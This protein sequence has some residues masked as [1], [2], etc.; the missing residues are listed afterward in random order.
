MTPTEAIDSSTVDIS[1]FTAEQ[2]RDRAT[3]IAEELERLAD[4]ETLTEA[5]EQRW[6][7]LNAEFDR[8]TARAEQAAQEAR[9]AD[10][11]RIRGA[12]NGGG[13]RIGG[14]SQSG[15]RDLDGDPLGEPGSVPRARGFDNP[16]DLSAVRTF[17]R[18]PDQIGAEMRGRALDAISR[19]QGMSQAHRE[20][21]TDLVERWD[22]ERGT[23]ARHAL[24]A[25]HPD[26][27]RA[28]AKLAK[29][30]GNDGILTDVERQ[31]VARAMSLT[32][33]AGGYLVPFQLD[34]TVILTSDGS[35]NQIRQVAREVV[36]TGDKWHGVSAGEIS[37]S[38]DAEAAEVSDDTPTFAQPS[39]DVHM[40]RGFV[41]ISI[42]A[43]Q[44]AANVT[45]EIGRLFARGKDTLEATKFVTGTGT[46]EPTGI[47]TAIAA[48]DGGS[49]DYTVDPATAETFAAA[50]V[51][52]L[53]DE[54][55]AR[56]R[57]NG[58]WLANNKIYTL[59]R[60]FAS[61]DGPDMWERLSFDRPPLLLGKPV[62]EAEAM[63]SSWDTAAS[64][65]NYILLFGDFENFV[66]ADRVGMQV[67]LIPHLFATANNRPSGQ[68]GW[69]AWY[70]TGSDSVNDAAFRLFNLVT[71]A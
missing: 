46:N 25:G 44:D 54:L 53:P 43:L 64:A 48:T 50:D 39:V 14:T 47:I 67:E 66:I 10:L 55:P 42:Q 2:C 34:P 22:D 63:D 52:G 56:Y 62:Y 6:T 8:V 58:A 1:E 13:T 45:Q 69:F 32:D 11:R 41:P 5:D 51:Y 33:A 70:R 31:A 59:I 37:W 29:K 26:Y 24:I 65:N 61:S 57:M 12:L 3:A 60:Q 21:A 9:E 7:D 30:S 27:L 20:A 35:V 38:F 49:P 15:A 19:M 16:F 23:I 18:T 36:A 17:D 71:A 40:A 68:R 4:T 28:F